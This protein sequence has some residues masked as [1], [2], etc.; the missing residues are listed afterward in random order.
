[1][2]LKYIY[3]F[4]QENTF[5]QYQISWIL[6]QYNK[7]YTKNQVTAIVVLKFQESKPKR[8]LCGL[9][10]RTGPAQDT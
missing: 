4:G 10:A 9:P 2:S 3:I 5:K 8:I 1:M 7:E 6:V